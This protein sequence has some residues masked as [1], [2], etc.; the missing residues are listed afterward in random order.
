MRNNKEA[1]SGNF[2]EKVLSCRPWEIQS[3]GLDGY[4][5]ESVSVE[6][7]FSAPIPRRNRIGLF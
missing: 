2:P 3:R 7:L 5:S 1:F 4:F 6:N